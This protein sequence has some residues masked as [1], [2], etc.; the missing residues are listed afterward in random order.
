MASNTS[1]A[2]PSNMKRGPADRHRLWP[3]GRCRHRLSGAAVGND[4]PDRAA[5][6]RDLGDGGQAS[7]ARRARTTMALIGNGAQ[8]EFQA[9]AFKAICGIT[10]V[11]LYDIDPA[12]TAKCAAQPGRA[13]ADASCPAP[14]AEE[15]IE[16]AQIITT[17]TAD[18]QYAT[19]L[20]DNMVGAGV[21]I[22]ARRR[23]L[24]RQDRTCTA[25][26]CCGRRSSSNTRRRPGSRA[27][28][29]SLPPTI[30]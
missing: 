7:R 17:V 28:S 30:R 3:S 27:R 2:I 8:A 14:R 23:R 9:L 29:S 20:T 4:H 25:T 21:H 1:T 26:S 15:A 13:R 24:P 10:E 12:A 16:G 5:H 22:N 6:R 18:K 19:I 11:R